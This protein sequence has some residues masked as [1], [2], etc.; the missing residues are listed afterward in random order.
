MKFVQTIAQFV[1][2]DVIDTEHVWGR[3]NNVDRNTFPI[4]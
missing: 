4:T 3:G 1:L 2:V